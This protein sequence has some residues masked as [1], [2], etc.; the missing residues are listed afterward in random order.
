[1]RTNQVRR[2]VGEFSP[3]IKKN[4]VWFESEDILATARA[5]K[6]SIIVVIAG[7]RMT[8]YQP[9]GQ[10]RYIGDEDRSDLSVLNEIHPR[11]VVALINN[12]HFAATMPLP[13]VEEVNGEAEC[14]L[15]CSSPPL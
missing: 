1:M 15:L 2:I 8:L 10:N 11:V 9:N 12:R 3:G 14:I 7:G 13:E 4:G 6:V 5:F